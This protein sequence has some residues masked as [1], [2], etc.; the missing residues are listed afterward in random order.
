MVGGNNLDLH[1]IEIPIHAPIMERLAVEVAAFWAMVEAG[2][3]P[4]PDYGKDGE[5]IARLY[6]ADDGTEIDLS[7][8]NRLPDL[9]DQRDRLK[10]AIKALD[11]EAA[12]IDAEFKHRLG[13]HESA[14][15]A[16]GR[17]VTFKTQNRKGY[18][19]KPSSFRVLR[20][21]KS[22]YSPR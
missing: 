7:D 10:D 14:K 16:G 4:E 8:D 6:P 5:T 18:V 13:P 3:P 22:K 19:V 11:E 2:T 1:L 20:F 12:E 21:L 15:L 17:Q 9:V